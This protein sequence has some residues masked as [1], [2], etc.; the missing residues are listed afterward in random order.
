LEQPFQTALKWQ[1]HRHAGIGASA[2][3]VIGFALYEGTAATLVCSLDTL[4][5]NG[6][7][8]L[9][10]GST[11]PV[12][13]ITCDSELAGMTCTDAGTGH[14]FRVSRESYELQ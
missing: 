6:L 10:Y 9:S 8:T 14:Y 11:W 5:G 2:L 12:K 4:R 13:P 3:G 1:S 7:P